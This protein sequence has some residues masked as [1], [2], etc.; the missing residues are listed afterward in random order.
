MDE[1]FNFVESITPDNWY[2]GDNGFVSL[3]SCIDVLSMGDLDDGMN[4]GDQYFDVTTVFLFGLTFRT[5]CL[6]ALPVRNSLT[7]QEAKTTS[8]NSNTS[9]FSTLILE[10]LGH[11]TPTIFGTTR[12]LVLQRLCLP[13]SH[14]LPTQWQ[15]LLVSTP[16]SFLTC[17]WYI[18]HPN[19]VPAVI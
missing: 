13:S 14:L 4:D 6:M 11:R 18:P 3:C 5:S 12:L 19:T 9:P 8:C 7:S 16:C 10:G 1:V 17:T 2:H 15:S